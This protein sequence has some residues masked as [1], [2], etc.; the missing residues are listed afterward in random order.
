M[1]PTDV[2][3]AVLVEK[4]GRYLIIEERSSGAVVIT[5]PGGH[6]EVGE[7]PEQAAVREAMEEAACDVKADELLGVYL[8]IHPQTR[9]QFLRLVYTATLINENT[10]T[11]QLEDGIYAVHWYSLA[12]IQR[13]NKDLRS[14][15]VLRCIEDYLQGKTRPDVAA[16]VVLPVQ[17]NLDKLLATACLL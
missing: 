13:R 12:D 6:I 11:R 2:T 14:P 7:S 8:W 9:Q 1:V 4:D 17:Q 5:Q 10:H 15:V 3:V 16:A